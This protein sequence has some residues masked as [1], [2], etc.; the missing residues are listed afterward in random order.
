MVRLH[1]QHHPRTFNSSRELRSRDRR[2]N[3][4]APN[5]RVRLTN[6]ERVGL[7]TL[8]TYQLGPS[9]ALYL[10]YASGFQNL[11]VQDEGLAAIRI[12]D[13][14]TQVGRQMVLKLSYLI[15]R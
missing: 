11:A 7:D 1:Q 13:P 14:A 6:D 10:G 2:Y 4:V 12:D 3:A 15:R 8:L 5:A 9:T